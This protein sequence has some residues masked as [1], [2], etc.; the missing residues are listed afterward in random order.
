[1]T[2]GL[3][4]RGLHKRF[5]GSVAL[6]GV[7]LDVAAGTLVALTGS[8]GAG[9]TTT[10]RVFATLLR[11]DAGEATVAGYDVVRNGP[12]VRR[13]IGAAFVNERSLYWR[14]TAHQNLDFFAKTA[15][16]PRNERA[17]RARAGL[18]A[19]GIAD[20]ADRSVAG[21]S[22]G[23][24]Q[25]LI[26]ARA[27]LGEPRVLL[28]DEPMRGLDDE[29]IE[30]VR[31]WMRGFADRGSAVVVA[32]AVISEFKDLCDEV[33]TLEHGRVVGRAAVGV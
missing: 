16:V 27:A 29:G 10:L 13:A 11:P 5:R 7:D 15:A 25:R 6:D 21:W 14:L 3:R 30:R 26:L 24:R 8:N 33:I 20:I 23:Q 32:G 18:E 2:K 31:V 1:M 9:K 4:A 12:A 17:N 22:A 19:L 28:L